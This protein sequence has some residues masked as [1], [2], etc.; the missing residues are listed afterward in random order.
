MIK[1]RKALI[2][3]MATTLLITSTAVAAPD[4]NGLENQKNEAQQQ[5]ESLQRE[6]TQIM[7]KMNETEARMV[8][9]GEEILQATEDLQVAQEQEQ[10]QYEE[11]KRCIVAMYENG[12]N[13]M[14]HSILESGSI[15]DILKRVEA[16][17]AIHTYETDRLQTYIE[18]KKKIAGLK[19]DL[20]E[21]MKNLETLQADF[22]VQKTTLSEKI[23]QKQAEV[24]DLESQIA[25]AARK[26]AEEAARKAEE[27]RRRKEEQE[28]KRR[29]EEKAK[30][31]QNSSGNNSSSNNSSSN[32]SSGSGSSGSSSSGGS[33]N[34]GTGDR[35]VGNAIVSAARS[36]IGVPYVWGG[37]SYSGID[38]SGL[39]QAAHRAVGI[40]IS[41][42]S[43]SQAVGG[44]RIASLEE[45]LP[46]DIIC[47]PG[48]VAIY[49]GN[50]RV[51]HA[52]TFGQNVKEASVYMG[53]SQPITAIRRYW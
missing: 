31:N 34:V 30:N 47:Y 23:S 39:T 9:T 27:E 52:P 38:C 48:H 43:S 3:T 51:I 29:E 7:S 20:E 6:F 18:T 41:R 17:Q 37:T 49:I 32:N 35:S 44:K 2:L 26:A 40:P 13:N 28:R 25:E 33:T 22:Q 8:E 1:F 36:Y 42:V 19:E 46:G 24:E 16:V 50:Y 12:N 11:V 53:A 4:V 15:A 21:E 5:V 14:L 45:A 10:Q